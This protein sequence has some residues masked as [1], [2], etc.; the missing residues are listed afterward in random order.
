MLSWTIFYVVAIIA[1]F[2]IAYLW[3]K[4]TKKID[5]VRTYEDV[6][7]LAEYD[8]DFEY[9]NYGFY[10]KFENTRKFVKW[11][12][13]NK[14]IAKNFQVIRESKTVY[15]IQTDNDTFEIDS[16][17]NGL[18]KFNIKAAENLSSFNNYNPKYDFEHDEYIIYIKSTI[19]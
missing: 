10:I 17:K 6:E 18:Y 1:V 9:H 12:E 13:I 7:K 4:K 8:G 16:S 14:I 5:D 11:S 15:F 19:I 3:D 2:Y